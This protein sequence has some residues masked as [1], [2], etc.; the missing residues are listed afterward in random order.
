MTSSAGRSIRGGQRDRRCRV[1]AHGLHDPR[2]RKLLTDEVAV[3]S[4]ATT[5]TGPDQPPAGRRSAG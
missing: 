4:V 1:A 2:I 5:K 3:A